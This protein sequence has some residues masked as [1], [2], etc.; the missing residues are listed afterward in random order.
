MST[1]VAVISNSINLLAY[2]IG[3]HDLSGC[4]W[5]KLLEV[6]HHILRLNGLFLFQEHHN[7]KDLKSLLNAMH[8]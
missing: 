5:K 3:L 4:Q 2:H 6:I 1:N 8:V 7:A